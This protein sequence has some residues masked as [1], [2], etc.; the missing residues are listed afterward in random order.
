MP[1]VGAFIS[2]F[3]KGFASYF[4][5]AGGTTYIGTSGS[6]IGA[7]QAGV[8]VGSYVASTTVLTAVS[9]AATSVA[10]KGM[11]GEGSPSSLSNVMDPMPSSRTI[12]GQTKTGGVIVFAKATRGYT[13]PSNVTAKNQILHLVI[14]LAGHKCQSVDAIYL[15]NTNLNYVGLTDVDNGEV[16]P[17]DN[18]TDANGVTRYQPSGTDYDAHMAM[19]VYTGAQTQA[20]ADLVEAT[21]IQSTEDGDLD[22]WP[23]TARGIGKTYV[24]IRMHFKSNLFRGIPQF[25]FDVT[26]K[27]TISF[28]GGSAAYTDNPIK[29]LYDYMTLDK[30]RGGF[31]VST[32]DIPNAIW[33]A[34]ADKCDESVTVRSG[35]TQPRYFCGGIISA[36]QEPQAIIKSL[37]DSCAGVMEWVAGKWYVWA[38][39]SSDIVAQTTI[40][41]S[42]LLDFPVWQ[43]N[44]SSKDAINSIKPVIRS[45]ETAW[46]PSEVESVEALNKIWGSTSG[47]TFTATNHGLE[48]G[49]RVKF[50]WWTGTTIDNTLLPGGLIAET[51]Y[52]VV[53]ATTNTFSVSATSGGSAINFG[54]T[55]GNLTALHDIY[56]SLDD[57]RNSTEQVF[58]M[59]NDAVMARRLSIINLRQARQEVTGTI[60]CKPGT[61]FS[62][63]ADLFVGDTIRILNNE[64]SFYEPTA[65][66]SGSCE[67]V[68]DTITSSGHGLS[69]ATAI[70][71]ST[72]DGST[73][74]SQ[75]RIYYVRDA[76][77]NTFKV[78][79]YRGGPAIDI[80]ATYLSGVAFSSVEGKLFRIVG[81]RPIISDGIFAVELNVRATATNIYDWT[82]D[83]EIAPSTTPGITVP[84]LYDVEAVTSFA[85]DS[86]T[87]QLYIQK[88]GS[89]ITRVKLSWDA[90]DDEYILA[91]GQVD[92]EYKVA[93]D[94]DWIKHPKVIGSATE[95]YL[96]DVIDG[97][98]YDF[99]VRFRN[100]FGKEGDWNQLSP[101]HTVQGKTVA[102]NEPTSFTATYVD[103]GDRIDL[104]WTNPSDLDLSHTVIGRSVSYVQREWQN[105][106]G[107]EYDA[108]DQG[109]YY[110]DGFKATKTQTSAIAVATSRL[111]IF[112][113]PVGAELR[114]QFVFERTSGSNTPTVYGFNSSDVRCTE[115]RTLIPYTSGATAYFI[116]F[117]V[118]DG[119]TAPG[120]GPC[121][122][123]AFQS[124]A[125]D[126]HVYEVTYFNVR[127]YPAYEPVAEVPVGTTRGKSG[128]AAIQTW[129][130]APVTK[131]RS[132][133]TYYY[134]IYSVD[135]SGNVSSTK[136]RD[137][138]R[139]TEYNPVQA[140]AATVSGSDAEVDWNNTG[141]GGDVILKLYLAGVLQ[142][143]DRVPETDL[144]FTYSSLANGNYSVSATLVH[145][146]NGLEIQ[147]ALVYV[148]FTI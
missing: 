33:Q 106:T 68:A 89:V 80:K 25:T 24:Y 116:D 125:G 140:F 69:D 97:E 112:T 29:C 84:S 101:S 128:S 135:T 4:G 50:V 64:L 51:Y 103:G 66:F 87:A 109:A 143:T 113:A 52:Y 7:A 81:Y 137:D 59:V 79:D 94:T 86:G 37:L 70:V 95:A 131:G 63:P 39:K 139:V 26:G 34:A 42:E 28:L 19:K 108:F 124:S 58:T 18:P 117:E 147:S 71:F 127:N 13:S 62:A 73:G 14:E 43:L 9:M 20:D 49:D 148:N 31:G 130:D 60:L 136:P 47:T 85:A 15:G 44:Q 30:V 12:Y 48:I 93:T 98:T 90:A 67:A 61:G 11:G 92:I 115:L 46:Q 144:D 110:P 17:D 38:Y 121:V 36:G 53:Y 1:Q 111:N 114:A 83:R 21:Q 142:S 120:A 104:Q 57:E 22:I 129:T 78:T 141:S 5:Y 32:T 88:D 16:L 132:A 134:E 145:P 133:R 138:A 55:T 99:R 65:S 8:T 77:T 91:S 75:N 96:T 3:I 2:G 23:T 10:T 74:L 45:I 27:S 40:T 126:A 72:I 35:V 105:F 146:F 118:D 6:A 54:T 122:G 123:F 56:L 107:F 102:P 119:T 82:D 41:E 100:A 76:A